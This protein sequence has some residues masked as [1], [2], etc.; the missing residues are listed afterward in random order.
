MRSRTLLWI[1]FGVIVFHILGHTMGHFTW[2]ETEDARLLTII[3]DMYIHKF[4]FMGKQQ[5]LGGHHDGYSLLFGIMLLTFAALTW[6]MAREM[7]R[8]AQLKPI[9]LVTGVALIACGIVETIYFFALAGGSSL[10]AG[11]LH[12]VVYFREARVSR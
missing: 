11:I 4:E 5:T 8:H 1:A 9:L 6:M 3:E 10:V 12:A 7:N 2:K